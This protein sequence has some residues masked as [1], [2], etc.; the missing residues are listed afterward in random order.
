MSAFR[1]NAG[2]A[3][4]FANCT[5]RANS[6]INGAGA[7]L[8]LLSSTDT[9]AN[10][11]GDAAAAA[12][13]AAGGG[14]GPSSAWLWGTTFDSNVARGGSDISVQRGCR[15]YSG[16]PGAS[17]SEPVIYDAQSG[18]ALEP[19]ALSPAA[20]RG[21]G[22]RGGSRRLLAHGVQPFDA[23][24]FLTEASPAFGRLVRVRPPAARL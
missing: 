8:G 14:E 16:G 20:A 7:A 23:D 13:A 11:S 1:V 12:A 24:V 17:G 19:W 3:A 2:A 15:V 22:S 4:T 9:V 5:F 6:A 21:G 18:A 10:V